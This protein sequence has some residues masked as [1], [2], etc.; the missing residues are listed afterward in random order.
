MKLASL[1]A[2]ER[3]FPRVKNDAAS[4]SAAASQA[5]AATA[6]LPPSRPADLSMPVSAPAQAGAR[7]RR[8]PLDLS[9]FM[10]QRGGA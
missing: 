2:A 10:T 1:D 8:G 7:S 5:V 9:S 3:Y 4:S 6:P